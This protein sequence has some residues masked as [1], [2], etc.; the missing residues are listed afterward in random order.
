MSFLHVPMTDMLLSGESGQ[1]SSLAPGH[2][3]QQLHVSG[4]FIILLELA[5]VVENLMP[6]LVVLLWLKSRGVGDRL[7][8]AF[9]LTCILSALV[10][11][12]LGLASYFSGG[13]YGG[14]PTCTTYQVTSTWCNISSLALLSYICINCHFA[15]SRLKRYKP[16]LTHRVIIPTPSPTPSCLHAQ[17][18]STPPISPHVAQHRRHPSETQ[19]TPE[20][21]PKATQKY[22]ATKPNAITSLVADVPSEQTIQFDRDTVGSSVERERFVNDH[23]HP[24]PKLSKVFS[25]LAQHGTNED[26]TLVCSS[27]RAHKSTRDNSGVK[28]QTHNKHPP[29]THNKHPPGGEEAKN[30]PVLKDGSNIF[31]NSDQFLLNQYQTSCE[32]DPVSRRVC[33]PGSDEPG[34]TPAASGGYVQLVHGQDEPDN[35]SGQKNCLCGLHCQA[36]DYV[37]LTLFFL[38][39]I[40]LAIS[41][42]PVVG[43]GPRP[44]ISETS[45]RSW[46][47]PIPAATKEKTFFVV[48]LSFVYFCLITGCSSG[49]SVCLQVSK[50]MKQERKRRSRLYHEE[51][52]VPDVTE[53]AVLE[54]MRRHYSLTCIGVA[55][56]LT[57]IPIVLMMTLQKSGVEV[58]EATLM[59]SNIATSLPGLLNPLLYSLALARY[60]SG[61][62]AILERCCCKQRKPSFHFLK[63]VH[64]NMCNS[65]PGE[66][67]DTNMNTTLN[68]IVCSHGRPNPT[69]D[70]QCIEII[71]DD[72]D[73][74][75]DED[76][77]PDDCDSVE[78]RAAP[79][80][81]S[82]KTPLQAVAVTGPSAGSI[83]TILA[84]QS[85]SPWQRHQ[86]VMT[87]GDKECLLVSSVGLVDDETGL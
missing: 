36:R 39:T 11:T 17:H 61:Y 69:Y 71:D 3:G 18:P 57:W 7:I 44:N 6:I 1:T 81:L 23:N 9:S 85:K 84:S 46:L 60:R 59:Y 21:S 72:D 35:K 63:E 8:A 22:K 51:E 12:P 52:N 45:C 73:D 86:E 83:R 48:F 4:V 55:G 28:T 20:N 77:Y 10:P 47:V 19:L 29:G 30:T 82:E 32:D 16:D 38:Y 67:P 79:A 80:K 49:I 58:S 54:D 78:Q 14:T 56:L 65:D 75:D 27:L 25:N 2:L 33:C 66:V 70:T 40:T 43:F 15:V 31:P 74:E 76:Y 37:S 64:G 68:G 50:R 53:L 13:W 34:P 42:L 62:K 5:L 41:S 87:C 24:S 26:K